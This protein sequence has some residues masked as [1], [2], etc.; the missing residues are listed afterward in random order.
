MSDLRPESMLRS[1]L[2]PLG[3]ASCFRH[4]LSTVGLDHKL[5]FSLATVQ[6][7][8]GR[9]R[10]PYSLLRSQARSWKRSVLLAWN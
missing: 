7:D 1:A 10:H 9:L 3:E 6:R 8:I 4:P 5:G 2:V